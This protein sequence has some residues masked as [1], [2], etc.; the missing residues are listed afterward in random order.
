MYVCVYIYSFCYIYIYIYRYVSLSIIYIY[1]YMVHLCPRT[2]ASFPSPEGTK[3]AT[4]CLQRDLRMGSISRD[5]ANFPSELCRGRSGMFSPKSHAWCR[6]APEGFPDSRVP[7]GVKGGTWASVGLS[8]IRRDVMGTHGCVWA[9][10]GV[11]RA[12]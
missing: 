1:I 4:P 3:R 8:R 11:C 9:R 10:A 2:L 6:L 12:R 7:N 5:L